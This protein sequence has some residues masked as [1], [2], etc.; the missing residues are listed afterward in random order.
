MPTQHI[1]QLA[2][3]AIA[4]MAMSGSVFAQDDQGR[5]GRGGDVTEAATEAFG[6]TQEQ[7]DKIREIRRDRPPRGQSGDE[8]QAWRAEQQAKIEAVLTDEQRAKIADLN[9]MREKMRD[10]AIAARMGLVDAGGRGRASA[11]A[12]DRRGGNRARGGRGRG[13]PSR[14]RGANRGR[15][16]DRRPGSNRG[17]RRARRGGRAE[18]VGQQFA[19]ARRARAANGPFPR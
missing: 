7:V 2:I 9:E 3:A 16:P 6:F 11:R 15:G 18:T 1:K 13:G 10:F 4:A 5:R 12:T 8:R 17:G 14:G 19:Q